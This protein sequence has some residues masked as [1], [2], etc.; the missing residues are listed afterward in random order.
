MKLLERAAKAGYNGVALADSKFMRW[1]Q[2]PLRYLGN[3]RRRSSAFNRG[4][5]SPRLAAAAGT[6][7]HGA[8]KGT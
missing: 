6:V 2:L 3:V 4:S 8:E 1:D 7:Y 5:H